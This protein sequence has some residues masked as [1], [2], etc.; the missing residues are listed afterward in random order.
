MK[1]KPRQCRKA[2]KQGDARLDGT[3]E[4]T[5]PTK[6]HLVEEFDEAA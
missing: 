3:E 4:R 6:R 1:T 5:T 2:S